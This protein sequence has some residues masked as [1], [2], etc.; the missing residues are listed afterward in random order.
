MESPLVTP[1]GISLQ[2]TALQGMSLQGMSLQGMSLQGMSLQGMSLQGMSLQGMSLQGTRFEGTTTTGEPVGLSV[3]A[4]LTTRDVTGAPVTVR[5]TDVRTDWYDA[6][7]DITLYALEGWNA[8]TSQWQNVCTP[9]SWGE[10]WAIPV[11]G[12]WNVTGARVDEPGSFTFSCTSGVI[13][14]CVRWGYK[15]WKSVNGVSLAPY[16]QA[17]TRMARADYCGDGQ[18]HTVNGTS[19]NLYD[20][21]GIQVQAPNDGMTFEA[22]WTPDGAYCVSKQRWYGQDPSLYPTGDVFARDCP[23]KLTNPSLEDVQATDQCHRKLTT[24]GRSAILLHNRSGIN[25]LSTVSTTT[26]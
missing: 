12:R 22:S 2:G 25:L 7:G 21:L 9:D 5:V 26:P 11:S 16:H 10:R 20:P 19:I 4:V 1:Q 14:K 13:A 15:P 6:S 8:S 23:K 18:S 3:G 24:A 17:C